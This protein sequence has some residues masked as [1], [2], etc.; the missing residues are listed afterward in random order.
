MNRAIIIN[1]HQPYAPMQQLEGLC[2]EFIDDFAPQ[3]ALAESETVWI[4]HF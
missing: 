2:S 3:K 1:A 4:P